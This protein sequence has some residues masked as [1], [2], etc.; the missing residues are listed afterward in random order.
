MGGGTD[1][2]RQKWYLYWGLRLLGRSGDGVL[3]F[4]WPTATLLAYH[5]RLKGI[6]SYFFN[7]I[8]LL[9]LHPLVI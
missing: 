4:L 7:M 1:E 8:I 6:R 3:P 2:R 9:Y 5:V